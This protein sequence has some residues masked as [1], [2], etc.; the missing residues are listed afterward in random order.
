[1]LTCKVNIISLLGKYFCV[2]QIVTLFKDDV[3]L[4]SVPGDKN[5]K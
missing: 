5:N 2:E 3:A 4:G 1:M